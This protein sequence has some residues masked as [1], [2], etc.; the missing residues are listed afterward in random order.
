MHI[1]S[2]LL[3][4]H[5]CIVL[6]VEHKTGKTNTVMPG[7]ISITV[8]FGVWMIDFLPISLFKSTTSLCSWMISAIMLFIW[9]STL[10]SECTPPS[11]FNNSPSQAVSNS[12]KTSMVRSMMYQFNLC[13]L[14]ALIYNIYTNLYE[15]STG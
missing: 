6:H 12:S 13:R 5:M 8:L 3:S 15:L 2:N 7:N 9:C 1:W 11:P 10:V 14:T 4:S